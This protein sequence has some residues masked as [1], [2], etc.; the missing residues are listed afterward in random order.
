MAEYSFAGIDKS[1][2]IS[3]G[4]RSLSYTTWDIVSETSTLLLYRSSPQRALRF[5]DQ[6]A[7]RLILVETSAELRQRAILHFRRFNRGRVPRISLCDA[8]TFA[9]VRD[10]LDR[11]PV[12][13]FDR[14]L[15]AIGLRTLPD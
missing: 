2:G 9:L 14:G 8:L 5:L 15:R 10:R 1:I 11:P 4:A 6:V 7:P 3:R 13:S 12:L